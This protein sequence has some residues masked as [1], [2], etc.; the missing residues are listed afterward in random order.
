MHASMHVSVQWLRR[1]RR[2]LAY[3]GLTLL[4]S[5][6]GWLSAI[7]LFQPPIVHATS[8]LLAPA[9]KYCLRVRRQRWFKN[10]A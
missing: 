9:P 5:L 3:F 1:Q 4:F 2:R 10:K 6:M 8:A 7:G